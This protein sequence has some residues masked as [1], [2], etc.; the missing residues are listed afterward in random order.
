MSN[1][2]DKDIEDLIIS[3]F[4][5]RIGRVVDKQSGGTP[6]LRELIRTCG[7]ISNAA[8]Q[9]STGSQFSVASSLPG[10][11]EAAQSASSLIN[12]TLLKL[13]EFVTGSDVYPADLRDWSFIEDGLDS[14]FSRIDEALAADTQLSKRRRVEGVAPERVAGGEKTSI[15]NDK[16]QIAW[17]DL[18]DNYRPFF[19]PVIKEKLNAIE[20]LDPILVQYQSRGD[21]SLQ[22]VQKDFGNVYEMEIRD[23]LRGVAQHVQEM[24]SV[25]DVIE[26]QNMASTELVFVDSEE[27]LDKMI[28]EIMV[29]GE[30]A[31]DLEHHD[32]HSFRGFTC[33]IQL[34]T[35][36]KDYIVDPF[37]L[38]RSLYKLNE[39]TTNPSVKK[40]LH[41]A[42]MDVQW[43]QRDFGVYIVNM[44]DTGQAARV[45]GLAGGYGLANLL[46]SFCKVKTNKRFQTSDW[47]LRPLSRDML[48]YARTDTHYLL[49]IRDRLES[50]LLSLG[51]A[52]GQGGNVA[53]VYGKKMLMQVFEKSFGVSCKVYRDPASDFSSQDGL[54]QFCQKSS[55]MRV[56]QIRNNPRGMAA[57]GAILKWREDKARNLDESKHFVLS[58]AVCFRLANAVPQT[59]P[60]VLRCAVQESS[61]MFPNMRIGTEEADEIL[62]AIKKALEESLSPASEKIKEESTNVAV[63]VEQRRRSSG[64][65]RVGHEGQFGNIKRSPSVVKGKESHL[66]VEMDGGEEGSKLLSFLK[67]SVPEASNDTMNEKLI[68]EFYA[69]PEFLEPDL[70][71]FLNSRKSVEEGESHSEAA[72]VVPLVSEFVAFNQ[73]KTN[74]VVGPDPDALPLTVREQRKNTAEEKVANKKTVKAQQISAAQKALEFVE[75]ELSLSRSSKKA[76]RK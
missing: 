63:N 50:L 47:R 14:I 61:A 72:P 44:F 33:L 25:R 65:V 22:L 38:F 19:V 12:K 58:N 60:Q 24:K 18:V 49:Y 40:T 17:A 73:K 39:F 9:I 28:S 31:I 4:D 13:L 69:C 11:A 26:F 46:D 20:P 30:V 45:L 71:S 66:D 76:S 7:E 21:K 62:A 54:A 16:P 70:A 2:T 27:Q 23:C 42:D 35:R 8:G 55:S 3:E 15:S 34:S 1:L 75:E 56:G 67:S 57:L 53:T 29:A 10:V 48:E 41:G 64:A 36:G 5:A 32:I 52:Q 51:G 59:V 74:D 37:P 6:L 68:E 43:L